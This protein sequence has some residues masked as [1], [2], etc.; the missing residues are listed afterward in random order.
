MV[1]TAV[2]LWTA[3]AAGLLWG[4][5]YVWIIGTVAVA[6]AAVV[7]LRSVRWRPAA[8]LLVVL[9]GLGI[10]WIGW[11][12]HGAAAHPLRLAAEHG[13]AVTLRIEVRQWPHVLHAVG[14]G[15]RQGADRVAVPAV[16]SGGEVL[17]LGSVADW[18]DLLPGQQARVSGRLAPAEPGELTVA[19]L[20]A[21]GTP[22][23]VTPASPWQLAA[24]RM[25][26]GLREASSVLP[27][28]SAGLLPGL[29][30]GETGGL[31]AR[32]TAEFADAGLTHL[33]A[34]S[35]TNLAVVTG[36]VLFGLRALGLGPYTRGAA[37]GVA[38]AGFVVL[39]GPDRAFCGPR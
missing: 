7:A 22:S 14:F 11:V 25:R 19:V 39:A 27:A 28:D 1:P 5:P 17:V 38:M 37:A 35:G 26:A 21:Q 13:D 8:V 23:E 29:V 16:V 30:V 2:V 33:M 12:M 32:L 31:S 24:A 20:Q 15:G 18:A 9:G 34:V 36:A 6:V 3:T 4:W 10:C